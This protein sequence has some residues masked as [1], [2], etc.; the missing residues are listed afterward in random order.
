MYSISVVIPTYNREKYIK[1]A[2]KSVLEQRGQQDLFELAEVI[3]VDDGSSDDTESVV[4]SLEDDRIIY[5]R[6]SRNSGAAA[7]RNAGVA[8]A[9]SEWIAFQDSDDIWH[10]DKLQK[11][12]ECLE[13]NGNV[14]MVSHKIRAL[15]ANGGEI[16]TPVSD[17]SDRVA[18]LAAKNYIGTPTMLVRKD[19]FEDL[20][21]FDERLSALEDWDFALRFADKYPIAMVDEALIDVDMVLEGIS[22]DASK[23]YDSRCRMISWNRDILLQHGCFNDA[24]ESLLIHANENNVLDSVAKMLELYL[25]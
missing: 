21:G 1:K 6:M 8:M 5:H 19:A 3:V 20:G 22:A 4:A 2:V 9:K 7:A 12:V 16:V 11:Q 17:G 25:Q 23:Y 14:R 15:I 18:T 13:A 24:T 10:P